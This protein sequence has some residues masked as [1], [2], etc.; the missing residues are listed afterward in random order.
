MN[1]GPKAGEVNTNLS[2][3][4]CI[5]NGGIFIPNFRIGGERMTM[6]KREVNSIWARVRPDVDV[7][8]LIFRYEAGR[9]SEEKQSCSD[10]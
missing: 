2:S 1:E 9:T 6:G 10:R 7:D 4:V 3:I 8:D 5:A